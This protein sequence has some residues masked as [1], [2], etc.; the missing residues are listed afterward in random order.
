MTKDEMRIIL[1]EHLAKFRAWSYAQLAERVECHDCLEHIEGTATDGTPYQLEFQAF[2]DDKAQ[3][4]IRVMGDL[5]A[6]PQQRCLGFL[7]I[8]SADLVDSF[9]MSPDGRFVGEDETP[10]A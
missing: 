5:C 1:A 3:G 8:Y 2:W 4:D 6:E 7:P 10:T 9:I